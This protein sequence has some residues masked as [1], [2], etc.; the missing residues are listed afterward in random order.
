MITGSHLIILPCRPNGAGHTSQ[1]HPS[2]DNPGLR[3]HVCC[4]RSTFP[5]G[6][7]PDCSRKL[8]FTRCTHA[9]KAREWQMCRAGR[10]RP[11]AAR[12]PL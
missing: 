5:H 3:S 11:V 7:I 9:H 8:S 12:V 10:L 2:K 1:N 4:S 6:P